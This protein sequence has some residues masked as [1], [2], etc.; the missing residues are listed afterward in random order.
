MG[1]VHE[2]Q[3][4]APGVSMAGDFLTRIIA[5]KKAEVL[6]EQRGINIAMMR[7]EA[8]A[9]RAKATPR[10]LRDAMAAKSS[11]SAIIAEFKRTSP[12]AGVIR[13]DVDVREIVHAYERGGASAISI[14][15]DEEHFGGS[16]ADLVAA[17]AQTSLPI[18]R[19]DFMIDPAQVFAAAIAGADAILLI[20]AALDDASLQRLRKTAEEELG[21]DA[22]VEA[23]TAEEVRR[24]TKAGATLIG[25]N[26]RDLHTLRV[27]LETS[28]RLI[29]EAPPGAI[30]ISESGLSGAADLRRLGALG[31]R[32]FLIG[33]MLMRAA[34]PA[35]S[36]R[37]LIRECTD[38]RED[39]SKAGAMQS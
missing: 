33:E 13:S 6:R 29:A 3:A 14:L 1:I 23:H 17:R 31:Y 34:N 36:L 12:S 27:S 37:D 16:L 39:C 35:G 20:V 25:V 4:G 2:S 22:L 24:A 19:K 5:A 8:L 28:E 18:L 21:M 10:R 30:M 32:G 26:N 9:V 11:S 15:T 38:R 7:D